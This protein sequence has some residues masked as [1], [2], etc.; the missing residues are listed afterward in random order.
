MLA[1]RLGSPEVIAVRAWPTAGRE[2][3]VWVSDMTLRSLKYVESA[4]TMAVP[5][6]PEEITITPATPSGS[7]GPALVTIADDDDLI[8]VGSP[9]RWRARGGVG[10]Y[11][12]RHASCPVVVVPPPALAPRG[13]MGRLSRSLRRALDDPAT[14]SARP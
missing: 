14:W 3:P 1:R 11:C 7:P 6:H 10:G 5:G 9:G 4:V 8:V 12:L 2:M 13:R